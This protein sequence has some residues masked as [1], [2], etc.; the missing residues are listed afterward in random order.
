MKDLLDQV[1]TV[2]KLYCQGGQPEKAIPLLEQALKVQ[3][4]APTHNNL[5][6]V[7][8]IQ[9]NMAKAI[10]HARM[11]AKLEPTAYFYNALGLQLERD[12]QLEEAIESYKIA[13]NQEP[14]LSILVNLGNAYQTARRFKESSACYEQ[15]F[16]YSPDNPGVH[17]NLGYSAFLQKNYDYGWEKYEYRLKHYDPLK[18]YMEEYGEDKLWQ[19]EN[20]NGKTICLYGEQG[21]GDTI[22]FARYIKIIQGLFDCKIYFLIPKE[23]SS[24]NR[25]FCGYG[26]I[27]NEKPNYDFHC[28]LMS[29]PH[30]LKTPVYDPGKYIFV[31]EKKRLAGNVGFVHRGNSDHANDISR[32]LDRC[33]FDKLRVPGVDLCSLQHEDCK[34]KDW[35]ETAVAVNSL[36]LII[37]V[38]TSILHLAAAMGKPTW[39]LIAYRPDPRWG[40]EGDQPWYKNLR[41]F[42]QE[43][44]KDWDS[45]FEIVRSEL[46]FFGEN[47][48][49][50]SLLLH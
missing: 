44:P 19:G 20:L 49:R 12:F 14:D 26:T 24:L 32:S 1:N 13:L 18:S 23:K 48:F 21:Y 29:L 35:Y 2:A 16:Q 22:Q 8:G 15:A 50:E 11:A 39:G 3:Q 9:R 45:V 41:L 42:R 46:V 6:A 36:D 40:C 7:Y 5:A 10:E 38:D 27:V 28:P 17:C 47:A 33:Y 4:I 37:T 30:R 25:L 34:F 43:T 31:N